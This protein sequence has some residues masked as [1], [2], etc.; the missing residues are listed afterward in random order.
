MRHDRPQGLAAVRGVRALA[1]RALARARRL[2]ARPRR[3]D[4]AAQRPRP[5]HPPPGG[6]LALGG[7]RPPTS[8][9][10]ARTRRTRSSTRPPT[11]STGTRR[12]TTSPKGWSTCERASVDYVAVAW[13]TTRWSRRSGWGSGSPRPRRSRRT[14]RSATSRSTCSARPASLLTY[15]GSLRGP[16]PHRGR[17]GLPP[18]RPASSATCTLVERPR[19][20][21]SRSRWRGCWSSRRTS[22][23]LYD[24]AAGLAPTRRWPRSRRR[25]SRRSTTTATTP[26]VGAAPRRRHRRVARAGCRPR[27]TPSGP[28]SRSSSTPRTSTRRWSR[29]ASPSTR[30]TL[31]DAC[32]TSASATCS[33]RPR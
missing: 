7:R 8:P 6:R 28:T 32:S 5:L 31:R 33:P 22:C 13:P 12:S 17:P 25:R 18:R 21:T 4:G 23:E 3:R 11:R 1:P 29:P 19:R 2:A 30:P 14:S 20:A 15:A 24:R 26:P 9:R 27:S 10:P 16:G